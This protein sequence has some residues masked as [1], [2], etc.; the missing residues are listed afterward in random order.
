MDLAAIF[1]AAST[2]TVPSHTPAAPRPRR[3]GQGQRTAVS[4]GWMIRAAPGVIVLAAAPQTWEQRPQVGL[5]ALGRDAWVSHDAAASPLGLDRSPPD[6]AEFTVPRGCRSV[7]IP[8]AVVHTARDVGRL[9]VITVR[10][11]R[12]ASTTRTVLDLAASGADE[13]RLGA[14]IDSAVRLHLTAPRVLVERLAEFRGHGRNG[15]RLL[16]KLLL[17]SGGETVLELHVVVEVT[18]Q[19]GHSNPVDRTRDAQRRNELQDLGCRV[20][21]YTWGDHN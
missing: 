4:A 10:G 8:R 7:A 13:A 6:R 11:F 17:D 3:V 21:E 2:N 20:Y 15:V 5:L 14:A 19:L 18:G 9:D 1:E 12:C 16:D